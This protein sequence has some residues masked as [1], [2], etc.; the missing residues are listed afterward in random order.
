M[1]SILD[2][3][4]KDIV[5]EAFKDLLKPKYLYRA[6]TPLGNFIEEK[7]VGD[8]VHYPEKLIKKL[9]L[10]RF[11]SSIFRVKE[12]FWIYIERK[13]IN[14]FEE[15]DWQACFYWPASKLNNSQEKVDKL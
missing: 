4:A 7:G 10:W 1:I 12:W 2:A 15:T 8:V 3:V 14:S 9:W 13:R 6:R 5:D 11:L